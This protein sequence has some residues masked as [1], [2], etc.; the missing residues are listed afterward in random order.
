MQAT[1]DPL[2]IRQLLDDA[3]PT[4]ARYALGLIPASNS[5][6][7]LIEVAGCCSHSGNLAF[8]EDLEILRSLGSSK[9]SLR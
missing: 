9:V 5:R 8:R 2:L 4:V 6:E 7:E 1:L 3:D